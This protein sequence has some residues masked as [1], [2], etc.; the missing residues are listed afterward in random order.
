[1][2]FQGPVFFLSTV[3]FIS[4]EVGPKFSDFFLSD[5]LL[6]KGKLRW[7]LCGFQKVLAPS[8][9]PSKSPHKKITSHTIRNSGALIVIKKQPTGY[10]S[11]RCAKIVQSVF[12]VSHSHIN[13]YLFPSQISPYQNK[14]NC[15]M[16]GSVQYIHAAATPWKKGSQ[17]SR[18]QP[19]CHYQTLPGR[20]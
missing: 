16:T 17:V 20:E 19:G 12:L 6:K 5:I 14:R 2:K 8:K 10:I 15:Q 18:P 7:G 9:N 4:P 11:H 1:M 3:I 13:I